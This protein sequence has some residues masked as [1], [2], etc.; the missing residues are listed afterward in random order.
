M[1]RLFLF[2]GTNIAVIFILGLVMEVFG[3]RGILDEQGVG[4]D[5]Y[6]LLIISAVVGMSG[7]FISL[8]ISKWMAIRSVGAKVIQSPA[9]Q[10]ENWLV[11][12]V[13]RQAREAGI[14]MPDVAI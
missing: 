8:A 1:N 9:N 2:L 4:I 11:E 12:T 3:L 14:G 7:S 13:S 10:T 5:L 6:A